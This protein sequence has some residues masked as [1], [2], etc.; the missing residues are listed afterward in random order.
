LPQI[1]GQFVLEDEQD[2]KSPIMVSPETIIEDKEHVDP[3]QN[4]QVARP[5]ITR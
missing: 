2:K 3:E 4:G 5:Q 1:A